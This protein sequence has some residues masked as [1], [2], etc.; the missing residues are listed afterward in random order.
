MIDID[1]SYEL[2]LS[3]D[4]FYDLERIQ[5]QRLIREHGKLYMIASR[6]SDSCG[7][8]KYCIELFGKFLLTE[9]LEIALIERAYEVDQCN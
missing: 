8:E 1:E 3:S 2:G 5:L 9:Q 6:S 4:E 7:P